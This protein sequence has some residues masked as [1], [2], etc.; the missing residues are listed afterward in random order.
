MLVVLFAVLFAFP[1]FLFLF[2]FVLCAN[3]AKVRPPLDG[4]CVAVLEQLSSLKFPLI[5]L[6]AVLCNKLLNALTTLFAR[7]SADELQQARLCAVLV[8]FV[9]YQPVQLCVFVCL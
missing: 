9:G 2:V 5:G 4:A 7:C 8:H 6:D 1:R 3:I